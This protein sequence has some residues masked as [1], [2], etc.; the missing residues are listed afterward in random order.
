MFDRSQRQH[1]VAGAHGDRDT[2]PFQVVAAAFRC[3]GEPPHSSVGDG[4]VRRESTS[5]S[6]A[7]E[8]EVVRLM[9][10]FNLSALLW[11]HADA[12]GLEATVRP[13]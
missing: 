4:V 6:T 8:A 9:R 12:L 13:S 1:V 11:Q 5:T 10:A 3:G 7:S 2:E